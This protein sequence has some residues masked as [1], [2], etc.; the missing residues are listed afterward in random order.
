MK[1]FALF[2]LAIM[3]CVGLSPRY[4]S[5]AYS[6]PVHEAQGIMTKFG[7]PDGPRDGE[8]GPQTRRGLCIFRYMSGLPVNRNA[9]DSTTLSKLR[10]YNKSYTSL[11]Q[12]PAPYTSSAQERL[13]AHETCQAMTLSQKKSSSGAHKFWRV[14]AIT[15]GTNA[16]ICKNSYGQWVGCNTPNG[17]YNLGKT[18]RGWQCSTAYPDGCI[19]NTT[20]R[21]AYIK[22]HSNKPAGYGNMYNFRLFKSGGWGVHGSRDIRIAPASH[23][24]VRISV[25]D[26][27]WMY[28]H[29]GNGSI[30]PQIVVT[31][32]Y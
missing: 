25:T 5:Y 22:N 30:V 7:I 1:R 19:V 9:L 13:V 20:G 21:F 32:A 12:I 16:K 26:S 18:T 31:G 29:V 23:G 3:M 6:N 2:A 27:D 28:D 11:S 14:M 15:T 4:S 17:T 24:C 10:S 8:D